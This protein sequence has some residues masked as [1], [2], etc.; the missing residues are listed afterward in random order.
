MDT[1]HLTTFLALAKTLNYQKA[2]EQLRYAPSTLFKHIQLLEHELGVPLF[3]RAGRQLKLT[4]QGE[5]FVGHVERIMQ[6]VH[7]AV[8]SVCGVKEQG[9]A[10]TIGGCELNTGNSLLELF[11]QFNREHPQVRVSMLTSS[12]ASV[13]GLVRSEMIDVGFC[14]SIGKHRH[15]G[16]RTLSLYEEPVRLMAARSN[17]ITRERALTY[18]DLHGM[19]FVHPHDS[20][21]FVLELMPRLSGRGVSFKKNA[22]LGGVHLVMEY[23][24]EEN[25]LTLI[26]YSATQRFMKVYDMVPLDLA[27]EPLMA[28]EQ[29]VYRSDEALSPAARLLLEHSVRYARRRIDE[30][31]QTILGQP[32]AESSM[33]S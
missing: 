8:D 6:D 21:C 28:W 14:Y 15:P 33:V 19:S 5:A 31:P 7:R 13:P 11:A 4:P 10:L 9:E 16:V 17:P 12:N 25:A 27:E 1:K 20:C 22:Y 26:P 24:H 32:G 18:E 29:I 2:A 23:A 3:S 30:H